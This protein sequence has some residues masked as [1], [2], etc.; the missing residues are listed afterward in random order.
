MSQSFGK[1]VMVKIIYN[2][3]REYS[4]IIG[5]FNS[6]KNLKALIQTK[7]TTGTNKIKQLKI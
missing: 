1:I 3:K 5:I 6:I 4:T 2:K 7:T